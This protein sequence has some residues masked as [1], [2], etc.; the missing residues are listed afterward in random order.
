MANTEAAFYKPVFPKLQQKDASTFLTTMWK[1]EP[2]KAKWTIIAKAY[3]SIRDAI[4][5]NRASLV[6]YL[7]LVCPKI[8]IIDAEDYFRKMNWKFE[9]TPD[10]TKVLKQTTFPDLSCFETG[11]L[12]TN[13]TPKDI[14]N[15]C[16]EMAYIP[17]QIAIQIAGVG[18]PNS[19]GAS[20]TTQMSQQSLLASSP[21]IPQPSQSAG[22]L[23]PGAVPNSTTDSLL[24]GTSFGAVSISYDANDGGY[25]WTGSMCDLY[26][27]AEGSIDLDNIFRN[28]G[29]IIWEAA[30]TSMP[31]SFDSLVQHSDV[32]DGYVFP[33]GTSR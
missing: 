27:P 31:Q 4:G 1:S 28:Q 2:F 11:I 18:L 21:I 30:Q 12:Y 6:T 8:G 25:Q 16:A 29:A 23:E 14:V 10:G 33:S 17:Q 5:K 15:F 19:V 24:T 13:M 7:T 20:P 26:D 9:T 32:C 22:V 3:S